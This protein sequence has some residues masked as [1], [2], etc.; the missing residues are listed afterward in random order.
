MKQPV[1]GRRMR[2]TFVKSYFINNL[3]KTPS[4][5]SVCNVPE[6]IDKSADG[7]YKDQALDCNIK[8]QKPV[9]GLRNCLG[10]SFR[11]S[12]R[13]SMRKRQAAGPRELKRSKLDD[14]WGR[15]SGSLNNNKN[16]LI[17][18]DGE[19]NEAG[20][21]EENANEEACHNI[22]IPELQ[23]WEV[24]V[25]AMHNELGS[26][27]KNLAS[28]ATIPSQTC[29]KVLGLRDGTET[30][31][32]TT[33]FSALTHKMAKSPG[34]TGHHDKILNF[35]NKHKAE[36]PS[37]AKEVQK[38]TKAL[39][40]AKAK[41]KAPAAPLEHKIYDYQLAA[42]YKLGKLLGKG[43]F[44]E[45]RFGTRIADEKPVAV[46]T[47]ANRAMNSEHRAAIIQN[48]ISVLKSVDHPNLV[49]LIDIVPSQEYTHLILEYCEGINLYEFAWEKG[50]AGVSEDLA[51]RVFRQL[52]DALEY[53]HGCNICHR[54]LKLDNVMI[55][56][57][58]KVTLIDFGF[59]LMV[60]DKQLIDSFCGTPNY[61]APEI[62]LRRPHDGAAADLWAITVLLY[63]LVCGEFP[64]KKDP[65]GKS[66]MSSVLRAEYARPGRLSPAMTAVF[67]RVFVLAPEQRASLA[68]L[69]R[70]LFMKSN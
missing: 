11:L 29:T 33:N 58:G 53:L 25:G 48:E 63:K 24:T 37:K 64:F 52:L 27:A 56:G 28:K 31:N 70:I 61:M 17:Q 36:Q 51:K 46:K 57:D 8:D 30:G 49:K 54:D 35:I 45:V 62:Y 55:G 20:M 6:A 40:H 21:K 44:A 43:S 3:V 13:I 42:Q 22:A 12:S 26:R 16:A 7:G 14:Y 34:R 15:G 9:G 5:A 66:P 60:K 32:Q 41:D 38:T 23:R 67:E 4:R 59:A 65:N 68:E 2:S 47:Y 1:S 10:A 18:P 19:T 39:C 50:R 69:K